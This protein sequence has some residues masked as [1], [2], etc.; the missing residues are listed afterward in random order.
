VRLT[1][2]P[3]ADVEATLADLARHARKVFGR[4]S[5]P[6]AS[7]QGGGHRGGP[8]SRA[9]GR[10]YPRMRARAP[11]VRLIG[12]E[13]EGEAPPGGGRRKAAGVEETAEETPAS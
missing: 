1:S 12:A 13:R 6:H 5:M 11:R 2:G 3:S 10:G 9:G 7:R 4:G 8:S